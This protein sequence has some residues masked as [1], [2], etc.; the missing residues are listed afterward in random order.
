[1]S[2]STPPQIAVVEGMA[3]AKASRRGAKTIKIRG[4]RALR[5]G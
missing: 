5:A 2:L 3:S 1:M 4:A